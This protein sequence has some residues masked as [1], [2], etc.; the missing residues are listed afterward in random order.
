M[1]LSHGGKRTPEFLALLDSGADM[2]MFHAD[3]AVYLGFDLGTCQ[4]TQSGGIG[5]QVLTF[6]CPVLLE[7]EKFSFNA[8]V[9]FS[10]QIPSTVA[11]LGR[12]NVFE[13]FRFR[14]PGLVRR[15]STEYRRDP[16][17]AGVRQ[18]LR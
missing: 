17:A 5:G 18:R 3:L 10:S 1:R 6:I 4:S 16:A 15:S 2:S 7:V 8:D 9:M 14:R 13:T 11:L 12:N